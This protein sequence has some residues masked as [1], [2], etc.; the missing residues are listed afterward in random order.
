VMRCAGDRRTGLRT[1]ALII[2]L[3]RA[4]LRIS[5]ALAFAESDLDPAGRAGL[6]GC[7]RSE[8]CWRSSSK[9]VLPAGLKIRPCSCPTCLNGSPLRAVTDRR[10]ARS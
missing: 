3:W 5:E 2:L 7:L 8:T 1:R 10:T 6:I 9:A 4:G